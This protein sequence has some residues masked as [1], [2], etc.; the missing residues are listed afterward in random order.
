MAYPTGSGSEV[1]KRTS[2]HAQSNT[3]TAF[4]WDGTMATTGTST[5]TVTANHIITILNIIFTEVAG[6]DEQFHVDVVN[7]DD[8]QDIRIICEQRLPQ[9]STFVWSDRLVLKGG[10]KLVVTAVNASNIDCLC[11]YIDQDWS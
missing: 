9:T 5:Y 11:S 1:L 6:A 10:D 3:A 7:G 4:R 8:S 2:I